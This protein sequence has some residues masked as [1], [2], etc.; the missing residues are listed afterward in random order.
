MRFHA[1]ALRAL[2]PLLWAS[3]AVA[4]FQDEAYQI[5]YQHA[6]LGTPIRANTFF[7]RPSLGSQ[8][9]LF[10]TLSEKNVLGAINPRDGS[11]VWRQNLGDFAAK[12]TKGHLRTTNGTS[13]VVAGVGTA[14]RSFDAADGKLL[15]QHEDIGIVKS[16]VVP[17]IAGKTQDPMVLTEEIGNTRITRLNS[18]NGKVVWNVDDSVG[19]IPVALTSSASSLYYVSLQS[20]MLKG[21]KVKVTTI[22][23]ETAQPLDHHILSSDNDITS[24]A[25]ILHVGDKTSAP[26]LV[27]ADKSLK[28]LKVNVLGKSH[29]E[30]IKV[31]SKSNDPVMDISVHAPSTNMAST[32][33]LVHYGTAEFHWAEVYH[34][35]AKAGSVKKAFDLPAQAGSGSFS[36][37]SV[38]KDVYFTQTTNTDLIL[39]SSLNNAQLVTYPIQKITAAGYPVQTKSLGAVSEVLVRS[40]SSFAVRSAMILSSGD[41]QLIRN[42]E[43]DWFR[44]ESLA[45]VTHAA[46][47]DIPVE[48]D[49]ARELAVESHSNVLSAYIH[50]VQRHAK[51]LKYFPGWLQNI[52]NRVAGSILGT[53]SPSSVDTFGFRKIVVAATEKGRL[54]GL[55][56]GDQGKVLWNVKAVSLAAGARWNVTDISIEDDLA[57]VM[58]SEAEFVLVEV[59]T[60]KIRQYQEPG[61]V[62]NIDRF[63]A[64]S[65]GGGKRTLVPIFINGAPGSI[66]AGDFD[67]RTFIVTQRW[68]GAL[69]GWHVQDGVTPTGAWIFNPP[70]GNRISAVAKRPSHDP[71]ASIGRALGDRNVLYKYLSPNLIVVASVND[72][73]STATVYVLNTVTGEVIHQTTHTA[74]DTTQPMSLTFSENWYAYTLHTDPSLSADPLAANSAKAHLL[75]I[76]ELFESSLPNDRG[77]LSDSANYSSLAAPPHPP[78]VIT[79]SYVVPAP[80]SHLTTTSTKQGITPR[81]ILAY[82]A[83]L[84]ALLAIP[85]IYLNPRRP[86]G[87]DTSASERE[88]GLFPYSPLLEIN[89]QWSL[90]HRREVLGIKG[91]VVSPTAMESSSLVF[92]FGELDV[93]GTR[94]AP[95]GAFD[96]LGKGFNKAQL[97]LTVGALAVGTRM[98]APFVS[99]SVGYCETHANES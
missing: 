91:I 93:F 82:S 46:F 25:S 45:G 38:G 87:R 69:T 2:V 26:V 18:A 76:S 29:I 80:L 83:P 27:W 86:V 34:V 41:V 81:S 19:E 24:E 73:L 95:I 94:T 77:P 90:S 14:V 60:G 11:L 28:T 10:Y 15:W 66:P 57:L 36:A 75:T 70:E 48:E 8:A 44:P 17:E 31:A 16:L 7:H 78:H 72:A 4:I 23:P 33:F 22:D 40:A 9:T 65:K 63:I 6:L 88:E 89:P 39:F 71:V 98:L 12:G 54:I 55:D 47:A 92:A 68:D 52:P 20:A 1:L 64:I 96:L 49:L 56:A 61:L 32:H 3:L 67:N 37:S 97:V 74:I 99:C 79:A 62:E 35:D 21:Y 50:R 58:A 5:D 53:G 51:D 30:T 42:G 59:M 43:L 13:E 85:A 84:A